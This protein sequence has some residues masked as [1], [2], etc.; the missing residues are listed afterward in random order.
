MASRMWSTIRG[1]GHVGR[2]HAEERGAVRLDAARHTAARAARGPRRAAA[3]R[4]A[5]FAGSGRPAARRSRR[6]D[7]IQ[8]DRRARFS[9]S[10]NVPPPVATTRWRIG[11]RSFR[12]S[13]SAAR[14]YGSPCRAKISATVQPLALLDQ[15]VDVLRSPAQARRQRARD[16]GLAARHEADEVDLVGLHSVSLRRSSANAGYETATAPASVTVDGPGRPERDE[17]ERHDE[18]VIARGV[19]RAAGRPLRSVD[20]EA[21]R[22][23][24]GVDAHRPESGHERR[25]AV[26]L[27]DAQL[28]RARHL[29][30]AAQRRAGRE[31]RQFV[32]QARHL[33]GQDRGVLGARRAR[34]ESG[35]PARRRLRRPP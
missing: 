32:D 16:G 7:A 18:P 15:V 30:P 4:R 23:L 27:L 8:V 20:D 17:R 10:A 21:V 11:C 28:G 5:G 6:D 13:R 24:V 9:G 3:G 25:D 34:H 31:H 1:R 19:G 2:A 14:K 29:E 35:R 33:V 22:P 12:M 26:A